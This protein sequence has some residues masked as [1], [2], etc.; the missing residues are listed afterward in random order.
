MFKASI[1]DA[2]LWKNLLSSIS[3]LVDEANFTADSSGLKLR[4]MDPSHVAMVD[5]ELPSST[6]KD[7]LCQIT[8]DY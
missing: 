5:F 4:S 6:F 7:Y 2:R 3:I 1:M 8:T